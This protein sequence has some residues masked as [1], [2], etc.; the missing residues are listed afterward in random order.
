MDD[1]P[2]VLKFL[3]HVQTQCEENRVQFLLANR[4]YLFN[5]RKKVNGYFHPPPGDK[6]RGKLVVAKKSKR[7]WIEVLPHEFGHFKQWDEQC[8]LWVNYDIAHE[9]LAKAEDEH[10]ISG[11]LMI[12]CLLAE[13]ALE[14]DCELRTMKIISEWQLPI[15]KDKYR[16]YADVHVRLYTHRIEEDYLPLIKDTEVRSRIEEYLIDLNEKEFLDELDIIPDFFRESAR[17]R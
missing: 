16:H 17:E 6:K 12:K 13:Q 5:S 7:P 10:A 15:D 11:E 1:D 3:E 9:E 2:H 14:F 4:F 8:A